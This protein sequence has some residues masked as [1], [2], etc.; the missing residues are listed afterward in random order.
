MNPR[1]VAILVVSSL[2][3]VSACQKSDNNADNTGAAPAAQTEEPQD[4]NAISTIIPAEAFK[5]TFALTEDAPTLVENNSRILY[6]VKVA[7]EGDSPI[8]GKGSKGVKLGL[9]VLG[10][11][12]TAQG[13]GAL[14]DF[15][16][17]PLPLIAPGESAVLDV[18]VPADGRL[19]GRKVRIALLQEGVRWYEDRGVIDLGPFQTEKGAFIGLPSGE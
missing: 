14:R 6:K 7:N 18:R 10:D 16:R 13:D 12:G 19:A 11:D 8:Y 4:P 5:V 15:N 1:L 3:A 9:Q 2:F 17:V